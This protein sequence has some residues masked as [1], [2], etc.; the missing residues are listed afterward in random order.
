M[1][2][3]QMQLQILDIDWGAMVGTVK[4]TGNPP[5]SFAAA[6]DGIALWFDAT[7]KILVRRGEKKTLSDGRVQADL[8]RAAAVLRQD[9]TLDTLMMDA[10]MH[11]PE[12]E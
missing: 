7:D 11:G 10:M 5:T 12:P 4:P 2:Q 1:P 8:R 3:L 6:L 9:P